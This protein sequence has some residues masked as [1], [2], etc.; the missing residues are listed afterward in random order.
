MFTSA[1]LVLMFILSLFPTSIAFAANSFTLSPTDIQFTSALQG[2]GTQTEKPIGINNEGTE[3]LSS[4][5]ARITSSEAFFEIV[6]EPHELIFAG[7]SD[8]VW[9]RPKTGLPAGNY[10]GAL[11]IS[12]A[13]AGNRVALL[14][15]TVENPIS[16][17]PITPQSTESR[18]ISAIFDTVTFIPA[19]NHHLV[20]QT[21][22]PQWPL[23][24]HHNLVT[25]LTT[26][27]W[28][29]PHGV[30][31]E[32]GIDRNRVMDVGGSINGASVYAVEAGTVQSIGA[33]GA[34]GNSV[35]IRYN[36]GAISFYAHLMNRPLVSVGNTV[37]RGQIIGNV[38]STGT[39]TGPHLHF[40]LTGFNLRELYNLQPIGNGQW[41]FGSGGQSA[42]TLNSDWS[43]WNMTS[44]NANNSSLQIMTNTS[45]TA[46]SNN[47]W[48]TIDRTSGFG[49]TTITMNIAANTGAARTG[50]I[51]IRAG[52][53]SLSR[54]I[55]INQPA[56]VSAPAPTLSTNWSN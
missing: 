32:W 54:T 42:D 39:S 38:G 21:F 17:I 13:N 1:M 20:G 22:Q 10:S 47:S 40:E 44:P 12:T 14:S 33:G 16:T 56:G 41:R 23:D 37:L 25:A 19:I 43:N 6:L 50:T 48:L 36:N 45:W 49:N 34:F 30:N 3:L 9:L 27:S 15:F 29:S 5:N 11:T 4:V 24:S 53:G 55:T 51:T 28:G 2:Y 8:T 18:S 26:Y 52:N 31:S 7:T 46:T 35:A